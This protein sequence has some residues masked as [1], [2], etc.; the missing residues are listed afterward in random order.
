MFELLFNGTNFISQLALLTDLFKKSVY[1]VF[2]TNLRP[3]P[4]Q[5]ALNHYNMEG[6]EF[7]VR[8]GYKVVQPT[9]VSLFF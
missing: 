2:P 9:I 1:T 6:K 4:F 7:P 5:S 3:R 8:G